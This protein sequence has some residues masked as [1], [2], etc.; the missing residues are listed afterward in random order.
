MC[1]S[2]YRV[3]NLR[4]SQGKKQY[5]DFQ[6]KHCSGRR[7]AYSKTDF[8]PI[9]YQVCFQSVNSY[10]FPFQSSRVQNDKKK[11]SLSNT[12]SVSMMSSTCLAV[13]LS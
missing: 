6:H 12:N 9:P 10:L 1:L 4:V 13:S 11:N 8:C 5:S 7:A 2:E 3:H